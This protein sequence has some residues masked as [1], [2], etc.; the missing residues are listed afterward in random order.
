M[1]NSCWEKCN[2]FL[3]Q[4]DKFL[5]QTEGQTDKGKTVTPS[6]FGAVVKQNQTLYKKISN[7]LT[8]TWQGWI[9]L[10]CTRKIDRFD[11]VHRPVV[12]DMYITN[13]RVYP[14]SG[15]RIM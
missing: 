4:T 7:A 14:W 6:S 2:K 5:L 9:N 3:L 13:K 10:K 12:N 15:G 8:V 11:A 1:Q